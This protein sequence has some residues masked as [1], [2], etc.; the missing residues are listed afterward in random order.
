MM[1]PSEQ[2]LDPQASDTSAMSQEGLRQR[3]VHH[4]HTAHPTDIMGIGVAACEQDPS[5]LPTRADVGQRSVRT[6]APVGQRSWR[7]SPRSDAKGLQTGSWANTLCE[8][9]NGWNINAWPASVSPRS[10]VSKVND[11]FARWFIPG[12]PRLNQ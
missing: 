1:K 2:R 10:V 8:R 7:M 9:G 11:R 3:F 6:H 4:S 5:G 12:N